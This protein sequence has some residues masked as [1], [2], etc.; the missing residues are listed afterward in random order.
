MRS[1]LRV[2]LLA[3]ECDGTDVGE[4]CSWF[5]WVR[6][7][8][9][10]CD[11]TLLTQA[12]RNRK[13]VS[14]QLP[15]MEVH[16]WNEIPFFGS[17]ERF[18]SMLKPSYLSFYIHARNWISQVS[19]RAG[20]FDLVHQLGPLAMRYPCPAT[21][22]GWPVII[23]PVAGSLR[24]PTPFRSECRRSQWFTRLR[25]LDQAR[26]RWDP[27]LRKSYEAAD[28]VIG[29]AP[30]VQELLHSMRLKRFEVA[31]EI[32]IQDLP[33][34][35][36]VPALSEERIRLLH[37]GRAVR[38]KGL[39]DLVRAMEHLRDL[40][41]V[42]LLSVGDGD[43]LNASRLEAERRGVADRV[44]FR[45]KVARTEVETLYATSDLFVFPSFREPSGNVV[46]EAMRHGLPVI[47]ADRGGPAYAVDSNS[48]VRIQVSAPDQFARDLAGAIR[49]LAT[50]HSKRG[51]LSEGARQRA[52]EIGLWDNKIQ[53][54]HELYR[55]ICMRG[56]TS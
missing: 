38:T 54:L 44:E 2:L 15:E 53:K 51:R 17:F 13:R 50:N 16:E 21:G 5:H 27:L 18:N 9:R 42:C 30:Y 32:G 29:V 8:A 6:G 31:S 1:R 22:M 23:G 56:A 4:S 40:P 24:T 41:H 45:G 39:R 52:A 34:R 14:Q 12:R 3:P 25:A 36:V 43:D 46:I 28:A 48:G 35:R 7:I 49:D 11:V 47:T 10:H 33:A 55:D 26:F 19:D 37:V 20:R